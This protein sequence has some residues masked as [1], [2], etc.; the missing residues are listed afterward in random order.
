MD[1]SRKILMLT[2]LIFVALTAVFTF[3]HTIQLSNF[4]D[5]EEEDTSGNVERVKTQFLVNRNIMTIW[6]ETGL[7]GMTLICSLTMEIRSL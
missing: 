3:I 4:L 7:A 6:L 1:I 5:L 2:I